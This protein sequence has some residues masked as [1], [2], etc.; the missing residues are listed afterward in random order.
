MALPT[1]AIVG[2]PNVGKSTFTNRLVGSRQAV[3][4]DEPGVTRDR[5][6]LK[7]DWNGRDFIVIDTGGIMPGEDEDLI[8]RD[9]RKQAEVAVEIDDTVVALVG[10][11]DAAARAVVAGIAVRHDHV[12]AVDGTAQEDHDQT[13]RHPTVWSLA[14]AG[15][16]PRVAAE[17]QH[18]TA[19]EEDGAG[20]QKIASLHGI[21]RHGVIG[22]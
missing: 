15:R 7:A 1:V 20:F 2:R 10:D 5:Q 4:H 14:V 16:R 8:L 19:A 3:V 21:T 18:Q 11:G 22:S 17:R 6:Y 13:L 12:Q 9:I